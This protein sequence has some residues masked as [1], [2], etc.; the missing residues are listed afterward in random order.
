MVIPQKNLSFDRKWII[1]ED[2]T[3]L[4]LDKPSG[5]VTMG[6]RG[7]DSLYARALNYLQSKSKDKFPA[8]LFACHRLDK[9]TS[10]LVL[11]AK[12]DRSLKIAQDLFKKRKVQKEYRAVIQSP[13]PNLADPLSWSAQWRE[14]AEVLEKLKPMKASGKDWL[15]ITL[16]IF[17]IKTKSRV[18]FEKG[19]EAYTRICIEQSNDRYSLLRVYPK[20]GRFHQIRCHLAFLGFPVAGDPIYRGDK[21]A[22]RLMLHSS[23]LGFTWPATKQRFDFASPL[24]SIFLD[25]TK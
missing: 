10:G 1:Y 8:K 16:P 5:M 18:D 20:T 6:A 17:G 14:P 12:D 24:P 19:N 3:L 15:E 22:K 4:V 23:V 25:I 21:S 13:V 11:F 7:E 9:D 2:R